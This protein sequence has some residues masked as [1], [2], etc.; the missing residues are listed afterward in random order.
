MSLAPLSLDLFSD[1]IV[2]SIVDQL[3][4][5]IALCLASNGT[6]PYQNQLLN[7]VYKLVEVYPLSDLNVPID[8]QSLKRRF[9]LG[10][11]PTM[12]VQTI[13]V[14]SLDPLLKLFDT[15]P[16]V[17]IRKLV[18]NYKVLQELNQKMANR[19]LSV[20]L[21]CSDPD[22]YD[23]E[24]DFEM[25]AHQIVDIPK[26]ISKIHEDFFPKLTHL[27][28]DFR[29][30]ARGTP[31]KPNDFSR[32][33]SN[34][35][36]IHLHNVMF[37]G[38]C[39]LP[40]HLK[41]L[42]L[43]EDEHGWENVREPISLAHLTL[44][45]S[46]EVKS[47]GMLELLE[48]PCQLQR[49][50][51]SNVIL[52]EGFDTF[53]K[54]TKLKHLLL[55]NMKFDSSKIALHSSELRDLELSL[56]D[57]NITHSILRSVPEPVKI[58]KLTLFGVFNVKELKRFCSLTSLTAIDSDFDEL[59]LIKSLEYIKIT[60]LRFGE[61]VL[62]GDFSSLHQMKELIVAGCGL[63]GIGCKFPTN[64][65]ILD[66]SGNE[67]QII[68]EKLPSKLKKLDLTSN[69]ISSLEE[70]IDGCEHLK[71]LLLDEN[72]ISELSST[73]LPLPDSICNL[74]VLENTIY[75]LDPKFHFPRSTRILNIQASGLPIKDLFAIL[76]P[77][78]VL[79]SYASDVNVTTTVDDKKIVVA[80]PYLWDVNLMKIGNFRIVWTDCPKLEYLGINCSH[81]F[82]ISVE[83][84]PPNICQLNLQDNKIEHIEGDFRMFPHLA[85]VDLSSNE[86][87]VWKG[88]HADKIIP[89]MIFE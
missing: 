47:L 49:L 37:E 30:Y 9:L 42:K 32:M 34:L 36:S 31:D 51:L 58:E 41:H 57:I 10:S 19:V 18:V 66:L 43:I 73:T 1:H 44:L 40:T 27:E 35:D 5:A 22:V 26:I 84:F 48:L 2:Q 65:E 75:K 8:I 15:Y 87:D 6:S 80:S 54:L 56:Y 74:S 86:L 52:S 29:G 55:H 89:S 77:K 78:V 71:E 53:G 60:Q 69:L 13:L 46:V 85:K 70:V 63:R 7:A 16:S 82:Q 4:F 24:S 28:L 14:T 33:P 50:K 79:F 83:D 72:S 76:P 68:V 25:A 39:G 11:T 12:L 59:P 21:I 64:L 61:E 67:I 81:M 3:P 17:R 20:A 88:Q 45:A 38:L 23:S 62:V